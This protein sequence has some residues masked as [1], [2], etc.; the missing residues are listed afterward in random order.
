MSKEQD[1]ASPSFGANLCIPSPKP[2]KR[3]QVEQ[4]LGFDLLEV[5]WVHRGKDLYGLGTQLIADLKAVSNPPIHTPRGQEEPS[6]H[7]WAAW[8]WLYCM[9]WVSGEGLIAVPMVWLF[10]AQLQCSVP[11]PFG[12]DRTFLESEC[13]DEPLIQW[14]S[15]LFPHL[16]FDYQISQDNTCTVWEL[17]F[18]PT[19]AGVSGGPGF[20][21]RGFRREC[22]CRG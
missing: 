2:L 20:L 17:C 4:A 16:H 5:W 15:W 1:K 21:P 19:L 3:W 9:Y 7:S 11:I 10:A 22:Q 14:E 18:L 8:P 6:T 12:R 13:W